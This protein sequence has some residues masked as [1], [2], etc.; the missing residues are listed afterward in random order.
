MANVNLD[1]VH[2][3][4]NF[5][6][7]HMMVSKAKGEFQNFDIDFNGSFDDL[8]NASVKVTCCFD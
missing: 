4:L 8:D 2:S 7:K 1:K 3:A 6:V 5:E